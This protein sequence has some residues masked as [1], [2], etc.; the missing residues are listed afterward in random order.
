[1]KNKN[2]YAWGALSTS[3]PNRN[4]L[5]YR[6]KEEAQAHADN[7]NASIDT[8]E[9]NLKGLWNKDYWKTKP[10]PWVVVELG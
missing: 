9:E 2:G 1:M 5:G 10:E 8:W 4:P 7:M 6:T 3:D